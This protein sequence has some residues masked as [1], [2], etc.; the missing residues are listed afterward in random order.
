MDDERKKR[1][2]WRWVD[3]NHKYGFMVAVKTTLEI[4]DPLY[5]KLKATAALRGKSVRDFVN[6]TLA[7]K[8][9]E[10]AARP[11]VPAWRQAF[12]G[13]RRLRRETKRIDVVVQAEFGRIE[14]EDW[15]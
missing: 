8:L 10:G 12:G 2:R 15:L 3:F 9:R 6:E 13:L 5:R 1:R 7:D 14:P 4:P 11:A